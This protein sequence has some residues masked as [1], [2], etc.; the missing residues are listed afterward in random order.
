M[1]PRADHACA[2]TQHFYGKKSKVTPPWTMGIMV[3]GGYRLRG[4]WTSSV[5]FLDFRTGKTYYIKYY[6]KLIFRFS[7]LSLNSHDDD[8]YNLQRISTGKWTPTL[9]F[10]RLTSGRH[11]HGLTTIGL[12]PTVFG[13]WNNGSLSSIERID[14]CDRKTGPIWKKTDNFMLL[15]REKFAY[16]RTPFEFMSDCDGAEN[17]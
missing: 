8:I 6:N 7:I 12:I 9:Y 4:A 13:G 16:T 3:T 2:V 10:P 11:Y 1:E 5:E 14:Y 15:P 17:T